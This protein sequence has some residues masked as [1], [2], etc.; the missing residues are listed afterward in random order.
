MPMVP[1]PFRFLEVEEKVFGTDAAQLGE[2]Q[3]GKAPEALNAIDVIFS[4]GEL[5]LVMVDAVL[6]VATQDE[7]VIGLP[8]VGINGGLG[9]H[10]AL[11]DRHQG[12]L[13]AVF[14]DFG[15]DLAAA[16]EQ[17]D[18][19]R[20]AARSTPAFSSD[21]SWSEIGQSQSPLL[22]STSQSLHPSSRRECDGTYT[23]PCG[24][25]R[26]RSGGGSARR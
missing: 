7:A 6:L 3:F 19:G 15:E 4:A 17:A 24:S 1:T 14:D 5:V 9:K 26:F 22:P 25:R 13:G 23:R 16:L 21:S 8:A 20:L 12:L 11:D 2:T 10:L 18:D